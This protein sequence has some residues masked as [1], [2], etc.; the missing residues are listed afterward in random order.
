MIGFNG[1]LTANAKL[2]PS[3]LNLSELSSGMGIFTLFYLLGGSFGPAVIG[4]LI[5]LDI[6]FSSIYY[7]L[8]LLGVVSYLLIPQNKNQENPTQ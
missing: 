3:T 1:I 8:A 6:P 2:V 7:I 4:R 5:D